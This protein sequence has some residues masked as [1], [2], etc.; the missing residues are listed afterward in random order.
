MGISARSLW[1][2]R[3]VAGFRMPGTALPEYAKNILQGEA[4][5]RRRAKPTCHGLALFLGLK[6]SFCLDS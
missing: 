6:L 2:G 1:C 5:S 4:I 3:V